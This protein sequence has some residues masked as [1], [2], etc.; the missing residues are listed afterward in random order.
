MDGRGQGSVGWVVKL[1]EGYP[2]HYGT[3]SGA[4]FPAGDRDVQNPQ[5]IKFNE[6]NHCKQLGTPPILI[7]ALQ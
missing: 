6:D 2:Y 5:E 1:K 3:N 7:S 4:L